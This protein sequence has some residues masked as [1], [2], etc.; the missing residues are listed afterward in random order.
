MNPEWKGLV[1][2]VKSGARLGKMSPDV[3]TTVASWHQEERDLCL[4]LSRRLERLVTL[5]LPRAHSKDPAERLR[6]DCENLAKTTTLRCVLEV[7]DAAAP[8]HVCADTG[9]RTL[10]CSMR[11]AA[12]EDKV[13]ARARINWL[14]RQLARTDSEEVYV[15]VA[16]PKRAAD[17]QAALADVREDLA[18][19]IRG[20]APLVPQHFEVIMVLDLAGKFAGSRTFIDALDAFV[21]LYYENVGQHLRAWV[22]PPPKPVSQKAPRGETTSANGPGEPAPEANQEATPGPRT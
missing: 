4:I 9:R 13:Q 16:W 22:P 3:Q 11:L 2:A 18:V 20:K 6:S 12:P 8:I 15:K 10:S 1:N 7:P 21:P 17:T 19:L 5:K 14:L